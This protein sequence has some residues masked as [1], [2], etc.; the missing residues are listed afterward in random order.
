[1]ADQPAL[2]M[3]PPDWPRSVGTRVAIQAHCQALSLQHLTLRH[4]R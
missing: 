1:M 3:M 2:P 4:N